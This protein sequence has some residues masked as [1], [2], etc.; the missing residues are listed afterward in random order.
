MIKYRLNI[1]YIL[2]IKIEKI[3]FKTLFIHC[4]LYKKQNNEE[5]LIEYKLPDFI[6]ENKEIGDN[7]DDFEILQVLGS[8]AFSQVLKVRSKKNSGIYALKKINITK[9][10]K[11]YRRRVAKSS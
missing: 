11:K 3:K 9:I 8:G 10:F 2:E 4:N 5:S 1:E 6:N 7:P